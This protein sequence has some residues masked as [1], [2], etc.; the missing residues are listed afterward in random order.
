MGCRI[1]R[2]QVRRQAAGGKLDRDR[3]GHRRLADAALTHDHHETVSGVGDLVDNAGEGRQ[4]GVG[5]LRGRRVAASRPGGLEQA[6]Q[7][8]HAEHVVRAK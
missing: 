7:G 6:A 5:D 4:V 8:V 3:R 2:R 1:G